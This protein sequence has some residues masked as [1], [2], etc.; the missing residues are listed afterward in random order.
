MTRNVPRAERIAG[1]V[2]LALPDQSPR[3]VMAVDAVGKRAVARQVLAAY[4][5]V[6]LSHCY[7]R[8][9]GPEPMGE[10]LAQGY[11]RS[12]NQASCRA[13][14]HSPDVAERARQTRLATEAKKREKREAKEAQRRAY[15]L[16]KRDA[17]EAA[18]NAQRAAALDRRTRAG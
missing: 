18:R 2:F 10:W 5:F 14:R 1:V 15:W 8:E 3:G 6:P 4:P 12:A 17:F 9:L 16:A 7:V 13:K 11:Q